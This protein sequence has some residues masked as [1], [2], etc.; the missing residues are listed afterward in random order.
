MLVENLSTLMQRRHIANLRVLSQSSGIPYTTLDGLYKKGCENVKLSTL[1]KL[2]DYF[3]VSLD[4]L[5]N[6]E[7]GR[8]TTQ[9]K[10]VIEA[11]RKLNDNEKQIVDRALNIDSFPDE[12][13]N[14]KRA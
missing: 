3:D 8:L 12:S 14:K 6:G 1:N 9:E 2:C 4:Y 7:P 11:Y 13:E 10:Q 5:V